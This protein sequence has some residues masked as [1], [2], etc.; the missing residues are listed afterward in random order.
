MN[1]DEFKGKADQAKGRV[2]EEAGELINDQ[3]LET[4]GKAER[5]GGK[6]REG[7]GKAKDKISDAADRIT[8]DDESQH[9]R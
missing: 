3:E 6:L 4:E 2:K 7:F 9:N 5:A 8:G 1:R